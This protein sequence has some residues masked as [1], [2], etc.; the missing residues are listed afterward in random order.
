[1][2]RNQQRPQLI[3]VDAAAAHPPARS[4]RVLSPEQARGV[5]DEFLPQFS[6]LEAYES[7]R[8]RFRELFPRPTAEQFRR[9]MLE[10]L[11]VD[12][13]MHDAAAP[14]PPAE[15]LLPQ[16]QTFELSGCYHCA[17]RGVIVHNRDPQRDTAAPD[18]GKAQPCPACDGGQHPHPEEHCERCRSFAAA[19]ASG[20][21]DPLTG[22]PLPATA[23]TSTSTSQWPR[24]RDYVGELATRLRAS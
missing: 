17:G 24:R 4:A 15:P 8:L 20:E 2:Q 22:E 12:R 11:E 23:A 1:M 18:F 14:A 5:R 3:P 21:I 13:A 10:D 6:S 16:P 19:R 9:F 7:S